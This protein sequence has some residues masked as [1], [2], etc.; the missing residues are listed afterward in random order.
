MIKVTLPMVARLKTAARDCYRTGTLRRMGH[1]LSAIG[2]LAELMRE[3]ADK[4]GAVDPKDYATALDAILQHGDSIA[5]RLLRG[6]ED[7]D[8]TETKDEIHA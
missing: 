5:Q 2:D 8:K 7:T 3:D 1:L 4:R 6:T